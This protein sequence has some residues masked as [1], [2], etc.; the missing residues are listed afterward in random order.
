MKRSGCKTVVGLLVVQAVFLLS[1]SAFGEEVEKTFK[2]EYSTQG[3][4]LLKIDN[5][6]GDV[7][8]ENWN[9]NKVLIDVLVK[10][11]HPSRDKAEKY[12]SMI[13]VYFNEND[14]TIEARTDID[15]DFSFKGGTDRSFSIDY[16]VKMPADF[17]LD[18]ENKY[19]NIE[20]E[21]LSGHVKLAVKYGNLY[22]ASLTRGKEEPL[23]SVYIAY[24]KGEIIKSGYTEL[25][26]RYV[27]KL[28]LGTAQAILLDSRYSK[29]YVEDVGSVVADSKY[30]HIEINSVKNFVAEGGYTGFE[31]GSVGGKLDID[32]GY[33]SIKVED[34]MK[35]FDLVDIRA[36]YCQVR[37]DVDEAAAYK[38]NINTSYGGIT[39]N[40]DNAE[41]IN[42]I[43]DNNRKSV[44]AVVGGKSSESEIKIN[45]S[46]GSVRVY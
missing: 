32:T 40:E 17:N 37:L 9:E 24:G 38:L 20:I 28:N 23:N 44:E 7:V 10:V 33:G 1:F 26:L 46:Y 2:K 43:Y 31:L 15:R 4:D 36:K 30:D 39:F 14:N 41:I 25:T 13:D 42:R 5:R 3:K 16:V 29:L 11:E 45:T 6:Y 27:G 34:L 18:L 19:G 35:D 8:I 12:L 21:E 22:V